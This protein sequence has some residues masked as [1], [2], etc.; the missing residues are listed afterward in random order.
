MTSANDILDDIRWFREKI[1]SDSSKMFEPTPG[2]IYMTRSEFDTFVASDYARDAFVPKRKRAS[3][4][5]RKH[6][7]R[8]KAAQRRC[9]GPGG[10]RAHAASA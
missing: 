2:P 1:L 5:W 6:V 9:T 3:K 7:R 10:T 8:M 4:G